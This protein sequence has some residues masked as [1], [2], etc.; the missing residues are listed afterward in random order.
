MSMKIKIISIIF[1]DRNG[2]KLELNC[3][4]KNGAGRGR[5]EGGITWR[6]NNM[7]MKNQDSLVT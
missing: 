2:M 3:R 7:L 4:K 1:S 6:L 5:G